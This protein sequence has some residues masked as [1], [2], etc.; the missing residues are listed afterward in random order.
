MECYHEDCLHDVGLQLAVFMIMRLTL[1]NFVELGVPYLLMAWRNYREGRQFH[2]SLFTNPLTVMPDMSNAEKQSKKEEYD[3]YE[4]MDEILILYGYT[5]LF[6]VAC[7][8]VP[9]LSFLY[10]LLECFLDQKKLILLYR[11]P[12]PDTAANN[13]PWDTAFDVFGILAMLTN[14]ALVV[15]SSSAFEDWDASTK[16]LVFLIVEHSMLFTRFL[17]SRALPETPHKVKLLEMQQQVMV[18][19]HFNLGGD[20][21]DSETRATAMLLNSAPAPHVFEQDNDDDDY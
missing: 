12:F 9:L 16:I 1:Q 4:D 11:R 8:W 7:P 5:T 18:H 2:T 21:D 14:T 6:V 10:C 17:I 20:E 13:E 3:I 19:R 15:F